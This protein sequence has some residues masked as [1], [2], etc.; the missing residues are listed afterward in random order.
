[1][2]EK[3]ERTERG[4]DEAAEVG[5]VE[6]E[7]GEERENVVERDGIELWGEG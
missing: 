7:V 4:E 2:R 6:R 3:R 5:A 1:M